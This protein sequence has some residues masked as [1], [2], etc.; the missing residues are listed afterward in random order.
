MHG[1]DEVKI[2]QLARANPAA[3]G[4]VRLT[5]R[6]NVLTSSTYSLVNGPP[7]LS[8]PRLIRE[9]ILSSQ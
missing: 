3:L 4:I 6:K 1:E 8:F 7:Y 2:D 5:I 9:G